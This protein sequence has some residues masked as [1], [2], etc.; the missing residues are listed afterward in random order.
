MPI[1]QQLDLFAGP[2]YFPFSCFVTKHLYEQFVA[3]YSAFAKDFQ[4]WDVGNFYEVECSVSDKLKAELGK[5]KY[6][7]Y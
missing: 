2:E 6:F 4:K 7:V 3:E 5:K 1:P